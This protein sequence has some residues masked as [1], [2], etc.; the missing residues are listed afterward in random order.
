MQQE[1]GGYLGD[2]GVGDTAMVPRGSA[3]IREPLRKREC[4]FG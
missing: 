4:V 1:D 2:V 3:M